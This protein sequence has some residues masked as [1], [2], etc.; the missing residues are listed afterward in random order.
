MKSR[1]YN[2]EQCLAHNILRKWELWYNILDG[3]LPACLPYPFLTPKRRQIFPLSTNLSDKTEPWCMCVC[4]LKIAF[5]WT[6]TLWPEF[7]AHPL[8]KH[9]LLSCIQTRHWSLNTAQGWLPAQNQPGNMVAPWFGLGNWKWGRVCLTSF[10]EANVA[11]TLPKLGSEEILMFPTLSTMSHYAWWLTNRPMSMEQHVSLCSEYSALLYVWT[12]FIG[13]SPPRMLLALFSDGCWRL[14]VSEKARKG[15]KND[16]FD[17][18][19]E[20]IGYSAWEG[21]LGSS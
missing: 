17:W 4:V 7:C 19:T 13:F 3:L 12:N 9:S 18:A 11:P 6:R 21:N 14:V 5:L 8:S 16:S 2:T 10:L 20:H 1:T 15:E